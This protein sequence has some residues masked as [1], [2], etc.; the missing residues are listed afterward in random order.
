MKTK[1]KV[2]IVTGAGRNIGE[3]ISHRLA[4]DGFAIAVVDLDQGR[5]DHVVSDLTAKGIEAAAFVCDVSDPVQIETTVNAVHG[6][7]GRIDV[8]VNNVAI[9]DNKH[10][11]EIDLALWQ[12]TMDITLTAPFYFT[13]CVAHKMV[14]DGTGG[15]VVN[16]SSTTGYFGRG[17]AIAYAAAKGGV[18][19]LTRAMAIQL[20]DHNIRVNS[21]VPN[22]IGSPVGKDE[23]DP[24]RPIV[25]LRNRPGVP[26]DL[27]NA[28]AFLVSDQSDFIV[29]ADL[30]VDGGCSVIM[31]GGSG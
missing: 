19:N 29:G 7:F 21:V 18:V 11:L 14:A 13:K 1:H 30:F 22:K 9:S 8:L 26:S 4:D 17:R 27:A 12:K 15:N 3:A 16:V 28:V 10:I 24:S 6:H 23:F 25:N 5:A 20:A 2:A 31:P